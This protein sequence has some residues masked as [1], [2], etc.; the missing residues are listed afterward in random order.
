MN[1]S[2]KTPADAARRAWRPAKRAWWRRLAL[3]P[4]LG[5]T[6]SVCWAADAAPTRA[7]IALEKAK[8]LEQRVV[9][10]DRS[11][12]AP[13]AVRLTPAGTRAVDPDG[14]APLDDAISCLARSIYWET[15]G[16]DTAE[17]EAVANVIM[18]RLGNPKFPSTLCGVVKQGS[19]TGHCQ[20][21]WWCDGRPDQAR[22]TE[23]YTE[24][25]EVA[26]RALN[27]TLPDRTDGALFF[28]HRSIAP[29]WFSGLIMTTE[30]PEFM[31]YRLPS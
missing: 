16:T 26:R 15:K 25:L 12:P 28:H 5:A 24:A 22:E 20:F 27:G 1:R 10:A 2:R 19:E 13:T 30:T 18:N 23:Q 7:E 4:L 11:V 31:F 21:S 29:G 9:E 3:L 6:L 14:T 8:V 17:M